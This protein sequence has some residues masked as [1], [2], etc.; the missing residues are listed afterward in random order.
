[1]AKYAD[2][3]VSKV[4]VYLQEP[5]VTKMIREEKVTRTTFLSNIGGLIGIFQGIS[6]ISFIEILYFLILRLWQLRK[7]KTQT[8]P[9]AIHSIQVQTLQN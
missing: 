8:K 6:V 2:E 4:T 9:S 5:Y 3:N 7:T 1:M